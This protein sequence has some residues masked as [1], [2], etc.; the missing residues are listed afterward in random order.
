MEAT[1]PASIQPA[2]AA[3]NWLFAGCDD[4]GERA[5]AIYTLTE[6]AKLNGVDRRLGC[7]TSS[8]ASPL[9]RPGTSPISCPGTGSPSTSN[10]RPALASDIAQFKP[11]TA[12]GAKTSARV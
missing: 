4:G 3:K 11:D 12:T 10:R 7:A 8:P 1:R 9:T 2:K 5:A 6:T